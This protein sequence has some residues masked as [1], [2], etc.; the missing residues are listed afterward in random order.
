MFRP[1]TA[2]LQ[3]RVLTFEHIHNLAR[4]AHRPLVSP[5]WCQRGGTADV[6]CFYVDSCHV[7]SLIPLFFPP[8]ALLRRCWYFVVTT[9]LAISLTD[10]IWQMAPTR[11][12]HP[13]SPV[14]RNLR[15]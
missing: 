7:F 6:F 1:A 2:S 11:H 5:R 15:Q 10:K 3:N 14:K 12:V 13:R 9:Q 4:V 8:F